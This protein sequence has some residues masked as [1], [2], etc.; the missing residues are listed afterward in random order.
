VSVD[1]F[2]HYLRNNSKFHFV[3]QRIMPI[4]C[5][6]CRITKKWRKWGFLISL[7]NF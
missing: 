6:G 1:R 7:N 4:L 5:G 2:L 3:H